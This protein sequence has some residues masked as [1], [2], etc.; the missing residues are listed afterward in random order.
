MTQTLTDNNSG[1]PPAAT[2]APPKKRVC[3]NSDNALNQT[4]I[5]VALAPS[6]SSSPQ[7]TPHQCP[8]KIFAGYLRSLYKSRKLP[9][10]GKWPPTPSKQFINLVVILKEKVSRATADDFTKATLRGKSDDIFQKKKRIQFSDL[11]KTKDGEPAQL[12][13]VEGAP[14]IGKSTFAWEACRKWGAGEILQQYELMVLLRLREKRVQ[15]AKTIAD[16]FYYKDSADIKQRVVEEVKY[17]NGAGVLLVLEGFDE[18]PAQLRTEDSLFMDIIKGERLTKATILVTSRHWASRPLLLNDKLH[19]PL[20]QHIEILGFTGKD[21]ED[22][23]ECMTFDD[24]S[25]L[26]GLK[27]YLS[28]YPII[29]SMMYVPL[30]C[31]IVLEVYRESRSDV[32]Q[33]IPKTMTELYTSLV[34][35]LLIRYLHDHPAYGDKYKNQSL[36]N[37]HDLPEPVYEQFCELTRIAYEGICNDEQIIF[38]DLPDGFESLGL[39]QCVPELYVDQGAVVSYNF[40]HL[41]LQEF[42]AAYHV[43][44]MPGDMQI[45]HFLEQSDSVMMEFTAGL[46]KL[47]FKEENLA[48]FISFIEDQRG[49]GWDPSIFYLFEAQNAN[50]LQKLK[51][52][53]IN[54]NSEVSYNI[55]NRGPFDFYMLGYCMAHSNCKWDI[56]MIEIGYEEARMFIRG[57]DNCNASDCGKIISLNVN[58]ADYESVPLTN[59]PQCVLTELT[60][61]KTIADGGWDDLAEFVLHA[62][63]LHT[64]NLFQCAFPPGSTVQLFNSLCSLHSFTTLDISDDGND[65]DL[66]PEDCQALGRLLSSL[67]SL[68]KLDISGHSLV[69]PGIEYISNGLKQ[70]TLHDLN[71]SHCG[72]DSNGAHLIADALCY[73]HTLRELVMLNNPIG[74]EGATFLAKMLTR[75]QT[76]RELDIRCCSISGVGASQLARALL[77]NHSITCIE[78][79]GNNITTPPHSD[80][81]IDPRLH[82]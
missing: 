3:S 22:Y 9:A 7:T 17:N 27:Q 79:A 11:A 77:A 65:F 78:L 47:D 60:S 50:L 80:M 45:E 14:G 15:Q 72:L 8:I 81:S 2:D 5:L 75:N 37:F 33:L 59:L 32:N 43:S 53:Q 23:L 26:P 13:L 69:D 10:Y 20:S 42:L 48:Q 55:G 67:K 35:T 30:N 71:V 54:F 4:N 36:P 21:I 49:R 70:S 41:T 25:L 31:A 12:V 28:C 61:I 63:L 68:T 51:N 73:N 29:A 24:P 44:L 39:M 16:L 40:L 76:L 19:R 6:T 46:T 58:Y 56:T 66:P 34:R 38:T 64:L 62:P 82:Y 18:L 52:S 57:S 1:D 74:D